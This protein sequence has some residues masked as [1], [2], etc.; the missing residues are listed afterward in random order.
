MKDI[1]KNKQERG[2]YIGKKRASYC[3]VTFLQGTAEVYQADY[4]S[5][6]DQV[7]LD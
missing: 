7:I 4:L 5:S 6:T 2:S 1:Y 3:K